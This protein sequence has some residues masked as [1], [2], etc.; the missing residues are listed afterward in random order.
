MAKTITGEL[1]D[2]FVKYG[3]DVSAVNGN[4]TIAEM[5]DKIDN[6]MELPEQKVTIA[7]ECKTAAVFGTNVSDM[8]TGISIAEN[9]ILGTLKPLT[10]G[11]LPEYWG[12]GYFIALQFNIND[13]EITYSDIKVGLNNPVTLDE[14]MNGAFKIE[15]TTQKLKVIVT[16]G[17]KEYKTEYDLSKLNLTE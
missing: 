1:I 5:L 6:L 13:P 2:I 16:K 14:D 12:A 7:P 17:G 10:E 3:G 8:Q 9:Y 15:S 4:E 11:Q